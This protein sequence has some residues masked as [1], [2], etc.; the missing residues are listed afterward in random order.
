MFRL[1][2]SNTVTFIH[3]ELLPS[4]LFLSSSQQNVLLFLPADQSSLIR[5][6]FKEEIFDKKYKI[7]VREKKYFQNRLQQV[8]F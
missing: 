3:F 7:V 8:A 2:A 1:R 4:V 6:F 5:K